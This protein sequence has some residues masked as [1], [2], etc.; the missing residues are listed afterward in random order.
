MKQYAVDSIAHMDTRL[1]G[2]ENRR[3]AEGQK[4]NKRGKKGKKK[5]GGSNPAMAD[6]ATMSIL[7][8]VG[9]RPPSTCH[10]KYMPW[11]WVRESE[12]TLLG[13]PGSRPSFFGCRVNQVSKSRGRTRCDLGYHLSPSFPSSALNGQRAGSRHAM[14]VETTLRD[15][16]HAC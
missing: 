13:I 10:R 16:A 12:A 15:K 11:S 1:L 3:R 2:A 8:C 7:N 9:R 5:P 6:G 4:N 14:Q